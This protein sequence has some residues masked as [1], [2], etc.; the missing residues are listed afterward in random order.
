M[1]TPFWQLRSAEYLESE[2]REQDSSSAFRIPDD[3]W[4]TTTPIEYKPL[5][6]NAGRLATQAPDFLYHDV[7]PFVSDHCK[8]ILEAH[9][10][11][12]GEFHPASLT[13]NDGVPAD[14]NLYWYFRL[15]TRV[16]AVNHDES[17]IE[18]FPGTDRPKRIWRLILNRVALQGHSV[19]RLKKIEAIFVSDA[20]KSAMEAAGLHVRFSV[21]E[22]FRLGW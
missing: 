19:F 13:T 11:Y 16:D 10:A 2:L 8:R 20:V 9:G 4:L 1:T 18:F 7:L 17:E 5:V 15:F 3:W 22:E 14:K 12:A 21:A 6:I